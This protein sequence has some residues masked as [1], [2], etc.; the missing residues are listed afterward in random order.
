M[1]CGL[2][3]AIQNNAHIIAG[4]GGAGG[5]TFFVYYRSKLPWWL[6]GYREYAE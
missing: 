4:G 6:G 5:V 2:V 3:E 1:F